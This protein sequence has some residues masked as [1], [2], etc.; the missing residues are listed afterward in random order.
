MSFDKPGLPMVQ[1]EI[2]SETEAQFGDSKAC[3]RFTLAA[4]RKFRNSQPALLGALEEQVRI[5][6]GSDRN[7]DHFFLAMY[8]LEAMERAA[9]STTLPQVPAELLEMVAS[10]VRLYGTVGFVEMH[11]NSMQETQ[12]YL[13]EGIKRQA[14]VLSEDFTGCEHWFMGFFPWVA[15]L[16]HWKFNLID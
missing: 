14:L 4:I 6:F 11:S 1:A 7:W 9:L 5:D 12:P 3:S 15:F 13:F 10:D 2:L 16:T 8:V